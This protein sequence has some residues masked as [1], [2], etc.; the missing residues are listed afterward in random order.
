MTDEDNELL[1]PIVTKV[2][3]SYLSALKA[4]GGIKDDEVDKLDKLLRRGKPPKPEEI[5]VA[6]NPT[7]KD[8]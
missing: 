7:D 1:S 6:L 2:L 5:D 4:D 8:E 3:D